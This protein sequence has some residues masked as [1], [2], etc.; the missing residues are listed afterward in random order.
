MIEY[1]EIITVLD[2]ASTKM[3]NTIAANVTST[4]SI[5]CH[6]KK[7]RD[8]YILSTVVLVVIGKSQIKISIL[9]N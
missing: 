6:S 7:G 2:I 4:A 9:I 5:N 3:T 1:D 8:C